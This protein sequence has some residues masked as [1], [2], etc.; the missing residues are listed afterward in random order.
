MDA[1]EAVLQHLDVEKLLN[2]YDFEKMKSEGQFIR[3][4]CKLHDSKNA[5]AFVINKETGLWF[6]HTGDCGGGDV[7]TL[8]QKMEEI[9]FTSSVRWLADFFGINIEGLS[10]VERKTN[11]QKE[12]QKFIRFMKKKK[13]KE[14]SEF[15]IEEEIKTVTK[16]RNFKQETIDHFGLGYVDK[17]DLKKR[18]DDKY[19][20]YHRLVF[21]IIFN[22]K[23]VGLSFR[24]IKS[25]DYPKWSHQPANLETGELLYNYDNV[26]CECVVAIVEGIV[27]VWAFHEINIPAVATFGSHLTEWQYKLLLKT[28]A[29]LVLAYDGDDAGRTATEKAIKMLKNKT[30]LSTINFD[31]GEDPASIERGELLKR[32]GE[33]K[34]L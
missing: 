17:V 34:K 30:N 20:L 26:K 24:R 19:T 14:I 8:V 7:F 29:D 32:Y 13:K 18:N 11:Y 9:K 16:F 31:E 15:K 10:I 33:R 21:P 27:D 2:H 23:Q 28:G 5:T 25:K 3:A 22:D 12:V 4:C 1:V 6:C